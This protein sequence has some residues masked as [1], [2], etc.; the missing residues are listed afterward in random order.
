MMA[1]RNAENF[2][3][4]DI[5]TWL[6]VNVIKNLSLRRALI[7]HFHPSVCRRNYDLLWPL[8]KLFWPRGEKKLDGREKKAFVNCG[9][10]HQR[11]CLWIVA[12]EIF[13]GTLTWTNLPFVQNS[14]VFL[15]CF[16]SSRVFL[17]SFIYHLN[18]DL[19][20]S[21]FSKSV[22]PKLTRTSNPFLSLFS[23][24]SSNISNFLG[25]KFFLQIPDSSSIIN[26]S[27][28]YLK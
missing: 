2:I 9:S 4:S 26:Y 19:F 6:E 21:T 16:R 25:R 27:N 28:I 12:N 24:L 11:K 14:H 1:S 20:I 8:E 23:T 3:G 7:S 5:L 10:F 18:S 15:F 17:A 13:R 22:V